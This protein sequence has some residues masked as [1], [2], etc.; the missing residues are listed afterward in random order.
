MTRDGPGDMHW[1]NGRHDGPPQP[2][3]GDSNDR[4]GHMRTRANGARPVIETTNRKRSAKRR[5]ADLDEP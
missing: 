4:P 1:P 5:E 2:R 3:R